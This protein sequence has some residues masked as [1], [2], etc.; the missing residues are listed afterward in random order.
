MTP[1]ALVYTS[2]TTGTSKGAILTHNNFAIN[3]TNLVSCWQIT[4]RDRFLLALPLFHV[5]ALGNGLHCWLCRAAACGC[6]NGS[7]IR[8]RRRNFWISSRRY[9]SAC[10][11]CTCGCWTRRRTPRGDRRRQCGCSFGLGAAAGAGAGRISRTFGHTILER[12]GMTETMMNMSNPY[13]GERRPGTVGFPLPGVSREDRRMANGRV[14]S[15]GRMFLPGYWRREDATR[16]AS[17]TDGSRPAI[18]QRSADGYYTLSR[19]PQRSDHFRRLQHLS[20]GD[21]GVPDGAAGGR[22]SGGGA[23]TGSRARRG[24]GGLYCAARGRGSRRRSKRGAGK[25]WRRS[26]FHGDSRRWKSCRGT[27][28]GRCRS[29]AGGTFD[30]DSDGSA[31]RPRRSSRPGAWRCSGRA[32]GGAR[33]AAARKSAWCCRDT[34]RPDAS[35]PSAFGIRCRCGWGRITYSVAI[36]Q[37][38]RKACAISSWIVRRSTIAPGSTANRATITWTIT[39][40]SRC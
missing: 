40:A 15:K 7:S 32:S 34:A 12:Y 11:R 21:R 31:R 8:P 26:R 36:D 37:V 17:P 1:A 38:I 6:W 4:D 30:A 16:A 28:S 20:P 27:H 13:A 19:T 39:F 22:R 35:A 14:V 9:S 18:G 5:H 3:A 24:P 25:S 23:G 29:T 2:G 10:R 33:K